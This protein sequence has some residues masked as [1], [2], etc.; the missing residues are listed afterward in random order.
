MLELLA[1]GKYNPN[2]PFPKLKVSFQDLFRFWWDRCVEQEY[3]LE[4]MLEDIYDYFREA[5]RPPSK[6]PEESLDMSV[7]FEQIPLFEQGLKKAA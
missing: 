3:V 7:D 4:D 1:I 6:E 2:K 5:L